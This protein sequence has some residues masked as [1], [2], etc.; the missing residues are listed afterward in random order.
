M[1]SKRQRSAGSWEFVVK[2]KGLLPKPVHLTFDDEA[3]GDEYCA[4]LEKLLDAGIVP[5][6]FSRPSADVIT[7]IG[8]AIV[9]YIDAVH[10]TDD[11][12]G[13]LTHIRKSIGENTLDKVNYPWAEKWVKT[14]QAENASP[15]TIRKKVGA[16]A[17]CLDWLVRRS[18][19]MLVANPLRMLPKRYATTANG[20]KDVERDRRLL[21]GEEQRILSI[22]NKEKPEDRQRP[23]ELP[24]A[25]ALRVM[26][27]LALETAMRLREIY[28][29]TA[30]QVD[31]E[32]RTVYLEK[33]KNGDRR[34][35]PLSSVAMAE[36]EAYIVPGMV[37]LFPFWDGSL[38]KVKL[39]A[40]TNRLSQQWRRVFS[41]AK[42]DGLHFHD[43]RHEATS[44]IFE[45][46]SL[47]DI[48]ISRI[49]GH[50]NLNMLRRY[51]NLRASDLS[52]RM[53]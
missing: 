5:E 43:V 40:T 30:D 39:R 4:H 18:D 49:T 45:R 21:E 41:A 6:E 47:S 12:I 8:K 46:T 2:R 14:L 38:E 42:C 35:V 44:R 48:E 53:W 33:T 26:F 10:I 28:T 16:L 24:D 50:K 51:S 17:R 1:A 27:I 23:L 37:N 9:E 52:L 29:L 31:L 11:D 32:Q 3:K 34:Q 15:S 13:I 25:E 19:T 20:R 7:T 36:L 22:L